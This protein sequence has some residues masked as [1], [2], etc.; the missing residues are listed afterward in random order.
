MAHNNRCAYARSK[1]SKCRCSCKGERH[2]LKARDQERTRIPGERPIVVEMD[3]EIADFLKSIEGK[4]LAPGYG[5]C[6][7]RPEIVGWMGHP[8][9]GG[10]SDSTGKRWW[11]Y[12]ECDECGIAI[13]HWK[14]ERRLR[15]L[16][17]PAVR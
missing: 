2:G 1:R 5:Y 7:H 15:E 13:S 8:H 4:Q 9:D 14:V 6:P 11:L 3:G 16:P 10:L 17:L 12:V